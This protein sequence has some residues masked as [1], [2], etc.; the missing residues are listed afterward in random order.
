ML[1][2]NNLIEEMMP[3]FCRFRQFL[4]DFEARFP[5]VNEYG[6]KNKVG[7]YTFL[8]ELCNGISGVCNFC[9]TA[10]VIAGCIN[11]LSLIF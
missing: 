3:T 9:K 7:I 1:F 2:H 10:V 4:S 8:I 6:F 5:A 11:R